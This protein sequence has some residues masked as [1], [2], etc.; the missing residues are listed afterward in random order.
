MSK[1]TRAFNPIYSFLPTEV[2]GFDALA[3]LAL[4]MRWSWNHYADEL[5][6]QLDPNLWTIT[7]NPWVILQTVSRDQIQNVLADPE[8]RKKV[9]AL[10]KAR[11][12]AAEAPAWF[13]K[14]YQ[15]TSL[16]SVAYFSMEF[17][18]SEALPIYSGGLGNV[19]GDQLKAASDLGVPVIGVG[20]LYQQGYFRQVIDKDGAQQALFPYNDPGQLP[21]TPLRQP[22]GEWLRVEVRLPGYS[23][24]LRAW[25]VQV[26]RVRLYLLDSNDAAN[27][28][29]HR[30]ITSELYGGGP[31]LRLKQ[32]LALGIGGWRL[33]DALGIQPEVCHLNEGHAAFAVLERARSFIKET[34][35]PFEV[36]LAVTRAGNL[37]TSHTAV[38]AGFDRFA[39]DLIEQYLGGYA[40]K[41]LG[42][43][44]HE[45]LALGRQNPNDPEENFNMAY[46]AIRGSGAVNG[47]SRLHGK[48]SRRLFER[49]FPRWPEDE[50]PIGHVTNG[51]HM[52]SWDSAAADELWTKACGKDRWLGTTETLERDIHRVSDVELWQMRTRASQSLVVYARERL[53]QL[54]AASGA[55]DETVE[56]AKHL[57][58]P[59]VLTLGFARRFA[60]YKRPNL[61]LHD[62]ERL[63]RLLT[64]AR[65]PVQL[66]IAG[67]AHPDDQAGQAMIQQWTRFIRRPE[68]RRHAIF[69][70]DY[71][72]LLTEHLVQGVDVWINTPRRP[73][74]ACGTSGMKVLVNGGINLSEL[75][76]W[77][78]EAYTPEVGWA[79]GDGQEH[80]TDPSWDAAEAQALYELLEREVIPEFYTRNDDG[81]PTA[82]VAR[83][84]ESM[85]RLTPRFS[86][87]R[88]VR[89]YT[90]QHYLPAAAAY[91]DRAADKAA[92]GKH[93]VDWRHAL[94]RQWAMLRFG[95]MKVESDG[96]QHMFEAHVYLDEL[97]PNAVRVELYADGVDDGGPVR[98]EMKR[99]RQ[100]VGATNGYAYS[101]RVATTRP[102]S[103]FTARVI[104]CCA[105]V[106]VPL[107]AACILWQR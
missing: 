13:Q 70:S 61:L 46:L 23:V 103:D 33:L 71:D 11:R 55:S 73:W 75:D 65:R 77:W 3:E 18:L 74:E 50:I 31:E 52:P 66:I 37:F 68:T 81:V 30:G 72:M 91:H 1:Q 34:G 48:V 45:L 96:A 10:V 14:N 87:N 6:Q 15:R 9:D 49:L 20:L 60:T 102:A 27:I 92:A 101:G 7:Q 57:F 16:T 51:V 39:P 62:P 69:L 93:A 4:D 84:R 28:P 104:P 88:T 99:V 94:E 25:Q 21:I 22:S 24:W 19:A 36:A 5:W 107:E 26:G 105:G 59:N 86:A 8:F 64:D 54:L 95:D 78:A 76:G 29:A 58:D 12:Q 80:D 89:E 97:D 40:Q 83:M 79:L 2:E 38:A 98:Q 63:T 85:A 67:K 106:A 90:E 32:E 56:T 53:S 44:L 42:L 47:V 100:L 41:E 43:T 35:Q 82:W 17:M